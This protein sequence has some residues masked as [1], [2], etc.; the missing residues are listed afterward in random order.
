MKSG[1]I[2]RSVKRH[3]GS[4]EGASLVEFAL[5]LPILIL[6]LISIFEIGAAF[7]N[8][9]TISYLARE[10]ARMSAFLGTDIDADCTMVTSLATQMMPSDFAR[11]NRIEIF[12]A[13]AAGN[14]VV[15]DTNTFTFTGTDST[16]CG[17][18]TQVITW[19][20]T[21][22]QTEVN[23]TTGTPPLDVIGVRIVTNQSWMTGFPPYSGNYTVDE[24]T[25]VRMEPEAFA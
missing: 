3:G 13:D 5:A 11:L 20:S 12:R 4:E 6:V 9:L 10:G 16:N 19:P 23:T 17:H 22:R 7:R 15:S 1:R 21:S 24:N 8:Y 18:W 14:Q 25:I 2:I